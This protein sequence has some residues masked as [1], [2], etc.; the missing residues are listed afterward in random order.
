MCGRTDA[1]DGEVHGFDKL[2]ACTCAC[3]HATPAFAS[4]HPYVSCPVEDLQLDNLVF[5]HDGPL[6]ARA[7]SCMSELRRLKLTHS[8]MMATDVQ[9]LIPTLETLPLLDDIDLSFCRL[10]AVVAASVMVRI[11]PSI[12]PICSAEIQRNNLNFHCIATKRNRLG[13]KI[14]HFLHRH[15][16]TG[17]PMGASSVLGGGRLVRME[18]WS[19]G[20]LSLLWSRRGS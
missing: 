4:Q 11:F 8:S 2:H 7:L 1:A 16:A 5:M 13:E 9:S 19:Q 20:S 3:M 12:F 17:L 14:I 15:A 6:L 18:P 10:E